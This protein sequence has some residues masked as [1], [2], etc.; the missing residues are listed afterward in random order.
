[1]RLLKLAGLALGALALI[2][3]S[4]VPS[5]YDGYAEDYV[6]DGKQLYPVSLYGIARDWSKN[7]RKGKGAECLRLGDALRDGLGDLNIEPRA[8]TGYWLMACDKGAAQGCAKAAQM[9][10][11]GMQHYPANPQLAMET[12]GKGCALGDATSCATTALHYYRGDVVTQDRAKALALWD[13]GCD[14]KNEESCRLKAGSLYYEGGDPASQAQAVALYRAGCDRKQGW[15]CSGYANALMTGVGVA[16]NE[17]QAFAI[18]QK[19]CLETT[20]DTVLA[21]TI[22]ATHLAYS[23]EFDDVER[24]SSLL[25]KACLAG[26]SQ[27][28]NEAGLLG[29]RGPAGSKLADWEVALS[30]RDGCDRAFG[31]ACSNLARLYEDGGERI[32]RNA[33]RAVALYD[34]ACAIGDADG[35]DAIR[36]L[37]TQAESLRARRLAIDPAATVE[38]QLAQADQFA[39]SGRGEEALEV[40]ARLME[41]A[42]AE[43]EWML[44]GWLYYGYPGVVDYTDTDNGFILM[45]NAA[46][47]G[48]IEALKWVSM[49]Y[50]EG[51]GVAVDQKKATDYMAYAAQHGNDPMAEA[52]YRSMLAE[53][54]RQEN[55]RRA[56]EMAEAAANQKSNF[57]ASVNASVDAWARSLSSSSSYSSSG[58]SWQSTASIMDQGNWNQFIGYMSGSTTAC[59][60]TNRYC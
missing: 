27:A 38:Q 15:G 45:E 52:I 4:K 17:S 58:S 57:W 16:A 32:K 34:K 1:M 41:E 9:I 20:G 21:C 40:V 42:N 23:E 59:P 33:V 8:A 7:C 39:K 5:A 14:A 12:A 19:G 10:E 49:A 47:Q 44:G 11:A 55:A 30:F 2:G 35:C 43:A 31:P 54:I 25:T 29:E 60:S 56:Q 53:P 46:R 48:H 50:W 24:A 18:A 13:S 28:C 6:F 37:G 3:A 36:R 22:Y 51:T 26:S